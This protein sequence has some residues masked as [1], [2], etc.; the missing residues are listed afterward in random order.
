MAVK[1]KITKDNF[2]SP[3]RDKESWSYRPTKEKDKKDQK[4]GRR[5]FAFA[6][7]GAGMTPDLVGQNNAAKQLR[8]TNEILIQIQKQ[9][10]VDFTGRIAERKKEF[11]ERRKALSEAKFFSKEKALE[12]TKGVGKFVKDTA[13]KIVSPLGKGFKGILEGVW[14]FLK[15]ILIG[16]AVIGALKWLSDPENLQKLKGVF[17]VM[18]K[19]WKWIVGGL[20]AI[21]GVTALGGIAGIIGAITTGLS[22]LLPVALALAAGYGLYRLWMAGDAQEKK[23]LKAVAEFGEEA[24][25]K[26]L[27]RKVNNP[28]LME[29][30]N[31]VHA[32]AKEQLHF[33]DTGLTKQY[34]MKGE[35]YLKTFEKKATG[36]SITGGKSYIVGEN[37]PELLISGGSGYILDAQKTARLL[38][39]PVQGGSFDIIPLPD[40]FIKS[41][42]D[43][44]V[45]VASK[46]NKLVKVSPINPSNR[47]MVDVPEILGIR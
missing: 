41:N 31:G 42:K 40:K 17:D 24:V 32:E 1:Q 12:S 46:A 14:G 21:V 34:G 2:N 45:K 22:I 4:S 30:I 47:Y 20:A 37:G 44:T 27:E 35:D 36:G 15:N 19:N 13:G 11:K 26:D 18:A 23:T 10:T 29:R 43:N 39:P 7:K 3:L 9:L 6:G 33:L 28:T 16:G 25:R 5:F 38:T 8:E